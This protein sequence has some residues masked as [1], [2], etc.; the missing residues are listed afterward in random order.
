MRLKEY[1]YLPKQNNEIFKAEDMDLDF[2]F[3]SD[4]VQ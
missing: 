3:L 2:N 1:L 4:Y